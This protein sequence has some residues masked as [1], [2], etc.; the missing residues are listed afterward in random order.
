MAIAN[1]EI[2]FA[3]WLALYMPFAIVACY[4][5]Y[6]RSDIQPI[7]ARHPKLTMVSNVILILFCLSLCLQR[8]IEVCMY[9]FF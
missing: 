9:V 5:F 1:S 8:V 7:K 4:L 2:F 6:I 3:V